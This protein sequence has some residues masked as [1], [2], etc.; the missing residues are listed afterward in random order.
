VPLYSF[1][2]LVALGIDY[3]IFLMTRAREEVAGHGAR[4]GVLRALRVTGGVI[5]SA[6]VVLAATFAALG[7]IPIL[8]LAQIAFIVAFGVLLDTLVVRSLL[9]PALAVDLGRTTWWPGRLSRQ[10]DPGHLEPAQKDSVQ[11]DSVLHE[12]P[13]SGPR[14]AAKE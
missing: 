12:Q 13:D 1:V 3:S 6:G 9:V 4:D 11:Q 10:Q 7:V 14:H 5:T 2:F 8:F